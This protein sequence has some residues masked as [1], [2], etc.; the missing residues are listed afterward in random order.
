MRTE[1][2][3]HQTKTPGPGKNGGRRGRRKGGVGLRQR[4]MP[5]TVLGM[6]SLL[7]A[8][9]IGFAFGG[10]VL[11]AYYQYKLDNV[12]KRVNDF[13]EG[14]EGR[15]ESARKEIAKDLAA[16]KTDIRKELE[17]IE[18]LRASGATLK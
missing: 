5:K 18:Q 15:R 12:E 17:P 13:I 3:E 4:V 6:V 14:F 8:A 10:T 9:S 11:Y 1:A 7:L 2:P 16:A